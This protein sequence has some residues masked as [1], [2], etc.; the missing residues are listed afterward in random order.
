MRVQ[1]LRSRIATRLCFADDV[2]IPQR[3]FTDKPNRIV[4]LEL[5]C[6]KE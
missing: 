3:V 1:S 6:G 4:I 5:A 2:S